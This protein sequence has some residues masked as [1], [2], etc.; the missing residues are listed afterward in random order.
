MSEF[1]G[2]IAALGPVFVLVLLGYACRLIGFPGQGFWPQAERF[3][4]YLLFP[5]L[6]VYKLSTARIS[7]LELPSAVA[8][9]VCLLIVASLL[10]YGLGIWLKLGGPALSS[11]YQGSVRF[12]TYV[13]LA[14]AVELFGELGL[15]WGAVFLA[16]MIPLV[17]FCCV[18]VF[19]LVAK[20]RNRP[21]LGSVIMNL[22]KNPL[23]LACGIGLGLNVSGLGFTLGSRTC[24]C[25]LKSG[26]T[27]FGVAGCGGWVGFKG[28]QAR[29]FSSLAELFFSNSCVI[30]CCLSYSLNYFNYLQWLHP[31]Y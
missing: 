4:Y 22:M 15:L 29:W 18:L 10:V 6:L 30:H 17:N 25:T 31:C 14:S 27:A 5:S 3:T 11:F 12:N 8:V 7:G 21:S 2:V 1:N 20:G 28:S 23:I 9:I 13:G 19:A 24:P 16:V 26:S